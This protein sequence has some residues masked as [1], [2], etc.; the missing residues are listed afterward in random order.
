MSTFRVPT[1][2]TMQVRF[3]KTHPPPRLIF[4]LSQ[5]SRGNC[6]EPV[7]LTALFFSFLAVTEFYACRCVRPP[8]RQ[9]S[10]LYRLKKNRDSP[11]STPPLYRWPL[12]FVWVLSST[13]TVQDCYSN[14]SY[15]KKKKKDTELLWSSCAAVRNVKSKRPRMPFASDSSAQHVPWRLK[16]HFS[17]CSRLLLLWQTGHGRCGRQTETLYNISQLNICC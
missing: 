11:A 1:L 4:I 10:R 17:A 13:W 12:L 15:M 5:G 6:S 8:G 16:N 14:K 3:D 9:L 7:R 2:A